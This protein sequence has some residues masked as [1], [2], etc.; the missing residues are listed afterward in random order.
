MRR[1]L[2]VLLAV[3]SCGTLLLNSCDD[4]KLGADS[5][6]NVFDND[7][8][9]TEADLEYAAQS[10]IRGLCSIDELDDDWQSRTYECDE[11]V[12]EDDSEP[13]F[14]SIV[15]RGLD[16]ALEYF[17]DLVPE[18]DGCLSETEDGYLYQMAGLGSL[19]FH[20]VEGNTRLYA[21]IDVDLPNVPNVTKLSFKPMA[22]INGL[23]SYSGPTY[24]HAG[25]I[26]KRNSDGTTWI[27]VRPAAGPL[28]KDKSYWI[29][30]DPYVRAENPK[31]GQCII[32]QTT[33]KFTIYVQ[34]RNF[35]RIQTT[36]TWTYAK[37]LMTLKTAKAAFFTLTTIA[38][39]HNYDKEAYHGAE[40]LYNRLAEMGYDLFALTRQYFP[41][42]NPGDEQKRG[43]AFF[44]IAYGSPKN[45]SKRKNSGSR[46]N[47]Q[48]RYVQPFISCTTDGAEIEV[49][50]GYV[51]NEITSKFDPEFFQAAF[52]Y[53]V[54]DFYDID[55][56]RI[57]DVAIISE[58]GEEFWAFDFHNFL[59]SLS[60]KDGALQ[61][62]Y[63][64]VEWGY[65]PYARY[66]VLFSPELCIKDNRNGEK[67][68]DSYTDVYVQSQMAD[69]A[70]WF[71]YWRAEE[72]TVRHIDGKQVEWSSEDK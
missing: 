15:S 29:C 56:I 13:K 17:F 50:E 59:H 9:D 60:K 24:Y 55:F 18:D 42:G 49:P 20:K 72:I 8:P 45:D 30:L 2:F 52:C 31:Q 19:K 63:N 51:S 39:K 10:I 43:A 12:V 23:Q 33:K 25:D 21:F 70:D 57:N 35:N 66:H 5:Q 54:A 71:D 47:C 14:R 58:A 38:H 7:V 32:K 6:K 27:C 34:D 46:A 62:G 68:S 53:S 4:D 64:T 69:E 65:N 48:V 37:S 44:D 3:L 1:T 61:L 36:Q 28:R 16:D 22:V 40:I 67:P 41:T 26:I 11:G